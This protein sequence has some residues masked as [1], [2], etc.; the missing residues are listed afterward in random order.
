MTWIPNVICRGL[1]VFS[2]LRWKV[3]IRFVY[4]GEIS[5]HHCLNFLFIT[6]KNYLENEFLCVHAFWII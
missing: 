2:E 4:I 6:E 5:D 1:F 3:I